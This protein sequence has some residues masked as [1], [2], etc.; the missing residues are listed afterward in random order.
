[1]FDNFSVALFR[2]RIQATTSLL[3]PS[4]KGSTLR[5]GFG[6]AF[7]R[8]VC[9]TKDK[10]CAECILKQQCAYSYIFETP[11]PPNSG[12]MR[13]YP[14]VP[15]PFVLIP[16][17][18]KDRTYEKGENI[19]FGLTLIGKAIDYLPYFIFTFE[20]FG[21]IG[22]GK[23]KG[24]FVLGEVYSL[25]SNGDEVLIYEKTQRKL[26][27]LFHTIYPFKE[28]NNDRVTDQ[29]RIAFLTPVRVKYQGNFGVKMD[30]H[31]LFRNLIRR[32]STLAYFHCGENQSGI[33][34]NNLI[35]KAK[36]VKTEKSNLKWFDW[37]RYSARQQAK[38]NMGGFVGDIDYKGDFSVF[39]PWLKVGEL[40]NVGKGTSFGLGKY[41]L[42]NVEAKK[43]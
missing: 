12:I 3:L 17:L 7:R 35:D 33:D 21:K 9:L 10:D 15:H 19:D 40:V 31:I 27:N 5:G 37:E 1:M 32:I 29:M 30:F 4:Y 36:N 38:M 2:L 28:E 23:G 16:P 41:Q 34:F 14:K 22:I 18:E 26:L 20:E 11:L 25:D 24:K 43:K 39:L 13:K 6:H 8:I 42:D